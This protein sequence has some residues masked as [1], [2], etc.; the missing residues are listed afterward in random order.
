ME[1]ECDGHSGLTAPDASYSDVGTYRAGGRGN[2]CRQPVCASPALGEL[3]DTG[4]QCTCLPALPA[5]AC[6]SHVINAM[7]HTSI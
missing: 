6:T 1:G 5:A 4:V 7:H 2:R 3:P